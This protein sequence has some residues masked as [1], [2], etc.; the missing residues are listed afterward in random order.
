[1]SSHPG[2]SGPQATP[3]EIAAWLKLAVPASTCIFEESG[4]G[5]LVVGRGPLAIR[6][7]VILVRYDQLAQLAGAFLLNVVGPGISAALQLDQQISRRRTA[8]P[9][10]RGPPTG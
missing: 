9:P 6:D 10:T 4:S 5:V 7:D 2:E 1:M 3:E 8:V